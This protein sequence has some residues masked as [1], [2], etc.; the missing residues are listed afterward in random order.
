MNMNKN[1]N[2]AKLIGEFCEVVTNDGKAFSG[3]LLEKYNGELY[4][5]VMEPTML[6][7]ENL[8]NIK[9]IK[10]GKAPKSFIY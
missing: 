9:S 2:V 10:I 1:I 7:L 5:I 3:R 6:K 4:F 8:N